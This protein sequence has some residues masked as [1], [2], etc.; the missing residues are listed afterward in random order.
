ML[1]FLK[2]RLFFFR[3]FPVF[4]KPLAVGDFKE[5]NIRDMLFEYPQVRKN[6]YEKKS[7]LKFFPKR[8]LVEGISF[9]RVTFEGNGCLMENPIASSGTLSTGKKKEIAS[10]PLHTKKD[11]APL[12]ILPTKRREFKAEVEL[13]GKVPF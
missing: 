3:N 8:N 5:K 2:R 10:L 9:L 12:C 7:I 4:D 11:V 1:N 13:N 6:G